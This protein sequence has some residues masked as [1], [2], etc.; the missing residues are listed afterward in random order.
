[1]LRKAAYQEGKDWDL[2]IP[3]LL[4]AYREVPQESTGFSPFEMLYGRDIRG[5]L[6]VLKESWCAGKRSNP[7]VV[8][9]ILMMR[10]RLEAMAEVARKTEASV[11]ERQKTL[12]NQTARERSFEPGEQVLV[13]SPSTTSKLTAQWQGPYVVEARVGK[14]N[15]K[16]RTVGRKWLPSMSICCRNGT[17]QLT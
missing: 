11:K 12:Y 10:D 2:L 6:D 8:A 13:L 5:P 3:Y 4:F 14:V 17:P 16:L 1:M 15:Y 7:N 9:Y